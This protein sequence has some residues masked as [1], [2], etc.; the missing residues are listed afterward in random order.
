VEA[1][2]AAGSAPDV[3]GGVFNVACGAA[4]NLNEVVKL[5]AEIVGH[6]VPITYVPG[7]VGDVKHSLADITAA[8]ARLGYRG[9]I[10]FAEG[11][12]RTVAWY[13]GRA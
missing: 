8:R 2:L 5:V 1:N 6:A 13:A 4:I 3:S 7:R 12:K 10:S 11:L 9:A